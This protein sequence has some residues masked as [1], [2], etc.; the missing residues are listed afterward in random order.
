MMTSSDIVLT[1]IF[2]TLIIVGLIISVF[3]V[4][5]IASRQR[6]R[7]QVALAQN[8]LD[9][10]KGLRVMEIEVQEKTLNHISEELHDNIG[11]HLTFMNLQLEKV[12]LTHPDLLPVIDP[13]SVTLQNTMLQLRLLSQSLDNNFVAGKGL[14]KLI[15]DEVARLQHIG[16][17]HVDFVTDHI[18]PLLTPD[19]Q[20]IVFR[21]FQEMQSN[22]IRHS[23]AKKIQVELKGAPFYLM[24]ADDGIG[25]DLSSKQNSAASGLGLNNMFKRASYSGLILEIESVFSQGTKCCLYENVSTPNTKT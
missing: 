14:K 3:F 1:I 10:E 2:T 16:Q 23:A 4:I 13:L 20:L 11:Q 25:F 21:I 9:F 7:Q 19:Q 22:C 24:V 15:C 8:K 6:I 17:P 18:E 5:L 12:K